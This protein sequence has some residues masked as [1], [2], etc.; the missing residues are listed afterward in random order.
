MDA[1]DDINLT[2]DQQKLLSE[3][4]DPVLNQIVKDFCVNSQFRAEYWIK[5]P[6]KLSNFDQIR[7]SI[8][9]IRV[10]LIENVES[11][12][13]KTQGALGEVELNDPDI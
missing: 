12:T 13:L 4:K 10:Q 3:M 6:R 5:G 2:K 8:R 1:I 9:K 11:I 7:H